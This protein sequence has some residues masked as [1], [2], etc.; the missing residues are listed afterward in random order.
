M[1][2]A[3]RLFRNHVLRDWAC[4]VAVVVIGLGDLAANP[5]SENFPGAPA[6]HVAFL[7]ASSLPLA[8]RRLWPASCAVSAI[9]LVTVWD[10]ALY[11]PKNQASFE[12]FLI[13]LAASYILGADVRGAR[14]AW[15]TALIALVILPGWLF[16]LGAG[17]SPGDVL[18]AL[19]FTV[20]AWTVGYTLRRRKEQA[21][22]ERARAD[23]LAFDQGRLAAEAVIEERSRIARE[24]HD[25]VAHSLSLMVV[26]ASAERRAL[27][28]G[29]SDPDST[30][31]VLE[32][33][34]STG[35]EAL[36]ELRRLL[37]L[38]RRTDEVAS[39]QPQPTLRHLDALIEQVTATGVR[40]DL[41]ATGDFEGLPPG[42]DLAAY[43]VVQ[44]ALTNIVKHASAS[45]AQVRIGWCG[46]ALDIEIVDDGAAGPASLPTGGHGLAGM[47]ERIAIYDGTLE[48]GPREPGP[49][50]RVHARLPV[51]R[52]SAVM[53]P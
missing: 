31:S 25:V 27:A 46:G 29:M 16:A 52:P 43:R 41:T 49:G 7:L 37:G 53:V 1:T 9:A 40:I 20:L 33:V 11:P 14:Q 21:A 30:R 19:V 23:R 13:M 50:F 38:I 48:T 24:L 6:G 3:L 22:L 32:S 45:V 15:T 28:V 47:R 12:A 17:Q 36:V 2:L 8:F 51:N 42:V 18:P 35:R 39:R 44:E 5:H 10:I 4:A 26:Q 34:E